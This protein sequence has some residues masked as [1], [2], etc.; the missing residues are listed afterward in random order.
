LIFRGIIVVSK[1]KLQLKDNFYFDIEKKELFD[2]SKLIPLTNKER[3]IF[4]L[5]S[6]NSKLTFTYQEIIINAWSEYDEYGGIDSLKTIIKNL[7]KKLPKDT[8]KNIFGIGY[9]LENT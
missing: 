1:Q 3:A 8:I 7:R 6:S 5:L 2:E 4:S 9:K